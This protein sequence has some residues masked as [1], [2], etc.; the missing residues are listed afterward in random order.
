MKE[1]TEAHD[2]PFLDLLGAFRQHRL[3]DLYLFRYDRQL[4]LT[5]EGCFA[6]RERYQGNGHPARFGYQVAARAIEPWLISLGVIPV[7]DERAR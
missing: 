1:L 2:V 7:R 5:S 6:E 3:D 4:P